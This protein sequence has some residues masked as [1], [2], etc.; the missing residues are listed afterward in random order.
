M[1]DP[2]QINRSLSTIRTELEFLQESKVLS[3]PQF[4]SIVAQLPVRSPR[5]SVLPSYQSQLTPLNDRA[6]TARPPNT[7]TPAFPSQAS[8]S[9]PAWWRNKHKTRTTPPIR[10]TPNIMSGRRIWRR[11][12][13]M[14]RCLGRGLRLEVTWLMMS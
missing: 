12:S 2:A 10:R 8:N 1:P 5:Y 14:R 4:Q 13:G 9:A 11:S 3:P 7:S 6:K